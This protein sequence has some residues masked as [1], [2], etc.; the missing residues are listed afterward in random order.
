MSAD[1]RLLVALCV[2]ALLSGW[3]VWHGRG[4][5]VIAPV[6]RTVASADVAWAG[7]NTKLGHIKRLP[8]TW[9]APRFD[10]SQRDP[11]ADKAALASFAAKVATDAGVA[12]QLRPD[13]TAPAPRPP[14]MGY[15]FIGVFSGPDGVRHV[16]IANG[17]NTVAAVPGQVLS[18]GYVVE[19]LAAEQVKLV[20]PPLQYKVA[21]PIPASPSTF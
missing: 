11:F 8:I 2:T 19:E 14:Q 3:S 13:A 5:S 1:R 17:D 9:E 4:K 12:P 15:R 7:S 16:Y 10:R 18:E 20:Y 6:A 21:I